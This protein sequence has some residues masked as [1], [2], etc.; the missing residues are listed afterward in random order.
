MTA[1][2]STALQPWSKQQQMNLVLQR[3]GKQSMSKV[4]DLVQA[5]L[6]FSLEPLTWKFRRLCRGK[7]RNQRFS[8]SRSQGCSGWAWQ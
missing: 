3:W 5:Y 1:V 8:S 7:R 4:V 6:K 2:G